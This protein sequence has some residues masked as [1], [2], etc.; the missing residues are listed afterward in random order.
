MN[1]LARDL[2]VA[3]KT[4]VLASSIVSPGSVYY[5]DYDAQFADHRF[6]DRHEPSPNDPDT[7]FYAWGTTHDQNINAAL[8]SGLKDTSHSL[9]S[10]AS[11]VN[12]GITRNLSVVVES[13]VTERLEFE[14][15]FRVFHP[16]PQGHAAIRNVLDS[17]ISSALTPGTSLRPSV[18]A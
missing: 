13:N 18:G 9:D 14:R 4:A 7:W 17:A 3:L 1:A 11:N 6:C 12:Y 15:R 16:K 2:N 8:T 5:V 10:S